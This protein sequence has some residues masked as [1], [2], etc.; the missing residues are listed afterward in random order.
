MTPPASANDLDDLIGALADDFLD[1]CDRGERPDPE[2]YAARHPKAAP[3]IRRALRWLRPNPPGADPV[4]PSSDPDPTPVIG[5]VLSDFRIVREVG[6]GGMGVVYEA[7]QVSLGRRVA[8]KVLPFA[9]LSDPRLLQRFKNEARAAAALDHPHIVKVHAVGEDRGTHYL[10]MQLID[11]RPLSDLIRE[12]QGAAASTGRLLVRPDAPTVTKAAADSVPD[13]A[14]TAPGSATPTRG[15]GDYFRQVATWGIQAAEALEH[16]H[17]LG[18]VHRDVKPGNLLLDTSGNVWVADFGLAKLAASDVALTGTGD[19][20]GTLRYMSPEQAGARHGLVDHRTDVYALG[21]TLYELLTGVPAVDG[22]DKADILHRIAFADSTPPR[23]LDRGIPAD[24]ETVVLKC[25]AKDPGERYATAGELASDLKRFLAHEPIRARRPTVRQRA[26]K[27]A[28]R[29]PRAAA[30]AALTGVLALA[31]AV[32]WDRARARAEAAAGQ[33]AA[34]AEGLLVQGRYPEGLAVARRAVD[35]LPRYGNPAVRRRATGLAADLDLAHKLEEARL[36]GSAVRAD[37]EGFDSAL[38][39]DLYRQAFQEYGVDVFGGDEAAVTAAL[40]AS[41]ARAE[42]VAALAHWWRLAA[43]G[44]RDRLLRLAV[45][46][47]GERG[48]LARI[49]RAVEAKDAEAVGRLVA[50]AEAEPPS[51]GVVVALAS[52]V[53][54]LSKGGA[55]RLARAGLR[56]HPGDF[57]LNHNLGEY[58]GRQPAADGAAESLEFFRAAVSLRPHSPG[59]WVNYGTALSRYGRRREAEAAYRRAAEL[60]PDYAAAYVNLGRLLLEWGRLDEAG[61]ATRRAWELKPDWPVARNRLVQ[62]LLKQGRLTDAEGIA[63]QAVEVN[64][65]S[66]EAHESLGWVLV[67]QRRFPEAEAAVR[68]AIELKPDY[69]GA[70]YGLGT[71][72]RSQ[73]RIKEAE[74]AF[75]R[76]VELEPSYAEAH[77]NLGIALSLQ[78][79]NQDAEASLRWAIEL[80]PGLPNAHFALGIQLHYKGRYAEAAKALRRV[81]AIDPAFPTARTHLESAERMAAAAEKLPEVLAGTANPADAQEAVALASLCMKGGRRRAAAMARLYAWAFAADPALAGQLDAHRYMAA[82]AAA[83]AATTPGGDGPTDAAGQAALRRQ[84]LGWLADELAAWAGRP[85]GPDTARAMRNWLAD[86][87]L[88]DVR[89]PAALAK[90]PAPERADW[91]KLWSGVTDLAGR[92]AGPGSPKKR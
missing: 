49:S 13:T 51:P 22:A 1:R 59:V 85:A 19:V 45:A 66:P 57:W 25:L 65:T 71:V 26:S 41:A 28:R 89:D 92:S 37:G 77:V 47:E 6:R 9:A 83:I 61:A 14:P 7:E 48:L 73:G 78:D 35:L 15:D 40:S 33:A 44:D 88:S 70:H 5:R 90:L 34:E 42:T 32:A 11:G 87:V 2:E 52:H 8:L 31:A 84:A 67:E 75:R 56:R 81:I 79:R 76:A 54:T 18:V 10:A 62:V 16:A 24:L 80:S 74:A 20:L 50:E 82:R 64:P 68:R 38:T 55:E 60:K 36:E 30:A 63:R 21:A 3:A 58:L 91:E 86:P 53:E 46:L 12:R 72:F 39:R 29:H 4:E 17:S 43:A 69:S 27:W 23:K